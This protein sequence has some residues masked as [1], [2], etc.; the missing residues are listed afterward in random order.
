M[1]QSKTD[2]LTELVGSTIAKQRL[3]CGLTQDQVAESLGIGTE[4]V[5]RMER[6]LVMPTVARLAELADIFECNV[7]DL[8]TL[9][10]NRANDQA[11]HL[12]RTLSKLSTSDRALIVEMVEQLATR[13]S[14]R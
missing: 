12:S 4:A 5:S 3:E 10:S 1:P 14:R 8:L 6:G 9:A 7:A 2:Q 11:L 13:L